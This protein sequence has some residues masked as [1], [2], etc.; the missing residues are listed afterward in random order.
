MAAAVAATLGLHIWQVDFVSAYLN[1][2][3][4]HTVYMRIPPG[5][6]GGEGKVCLLRKTLYGMMQGRHVLTAAFA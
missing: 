5:F 4:K 3:L 2:V 6:P 1:S